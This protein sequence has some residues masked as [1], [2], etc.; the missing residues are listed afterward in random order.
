MQVFG[1]LR[2]QHSARQREGELTPLKYRLE[3]VREAAFQQSLRQMKKAAEQQW[4][5]QQKALLEQQAIERQRAEP[6][7]K[8]RESEALKWTIER[9]DELVEAAKQA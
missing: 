5:L 8:K 6:E 1:R 3:Q 9:M 2:F 4:A 7:A